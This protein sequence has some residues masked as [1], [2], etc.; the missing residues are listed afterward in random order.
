MIILQITI[1]I[2]IIIVG[3]PISANLSISR[4][5]GFN[6]RNWKHFTAEQ[7]HPT[8]SVF[9]LLHYCTGSG[10]FILKVELRAHQA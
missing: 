10:H 2:I 3:V 7:S 4:L 1:I 6:S 8:F 5:C 9:Y